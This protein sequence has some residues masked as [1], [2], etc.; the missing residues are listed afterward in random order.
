MNPPVD[1][2]TPNRHPS[3]ATCSFIR[4]DELTNA[5]SE[6][7]RRLAS[8]RTESAPFVDE[9]WMRAW[10]AAFA[11]ADHVCLCVRRDARIAGLAFMAHFRDRWAGKAL[12]LL[13]SATNQWSY[14]YEFL[15][16]DDDDE[17]YRRLWT[18]LFSENKWDV[19]R[20]SWVVD[21]TPTMQWG[22]R[23]ARE[24]G[25]SPVVVECSPSPW[26][27]LPGRGE[28]WDKGLKSKFKS[29]LRNREKRIEALGDVEFT[30][31]RDTNGLE[32]AVRTFYD[33]EAKGWKGEEGTAIAMQHGA[34]SLF[35]GL[36]RGTP[37]DVWV[38]ILFVGGRPVAA[39]FLRVWERTMFLFKTSYDP[40]FSAYSPGQLITARV[41]RYGI[42]NGM[43]ALD[44]L[45]APMAWKTDWV[46]DARPNV[47]LVF[48]APSTAGRYA[49]WTRYGFKN[50]LK[51]VPFAVPLVRRLRGL[52]RKG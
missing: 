29:N 40:E 10:I 50:E 5:D 4:V 36:L 16:R 48:C 51:K 9:T 34:R 43:E 23:V 25:W 13:E 6:E 46:P 7:W 19:I 47:Q 38:P 32:G 27:K 37:P 42:E 35:D 24:L 2:V 8:R 49:Y 20:L 31:V 26:R 15:A 1:T 18:T 33:I 41:V 22:L 17:I 45:G 28:P 14:R 52:R 39:Q 11:P 21:E 12:N 3:D 30:V 44:F